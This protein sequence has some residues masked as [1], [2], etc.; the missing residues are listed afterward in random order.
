G[1]DVSEPETL[2]A[3]LLADITRRDTDGELIA[4]P[5]EWDEVENSEPPKIR[6][7]IPGRVQ[8]GTAGGVGDRVL[9]RVEKLE[10]GVRDG[11]AY[12]GRILKVID[13]GK[14]RVPGIFRKNTDG[15]GRL[16]PVDKKQAGR[17][18]KISKP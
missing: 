5:A 13:H 6:N 1:K 7:H 12:R 2:P 10:D 17:Q 9:L 3:T 18:L 14:T 8:P 15:A 4:V 16:I 11:V